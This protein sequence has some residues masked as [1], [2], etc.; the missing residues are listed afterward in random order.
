M[1]AKLKISGTKE[2]I[3][4]IVNNF[5]KQSEFE[6]IPTSDYMESEQK[7]GEYYK[8]VLVVVINGE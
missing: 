6:V 7:Y 3:D 5:E 4:S 8:Y 1:R 2:A